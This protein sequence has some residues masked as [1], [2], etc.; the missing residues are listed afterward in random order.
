LT[1]AEFV[2]IMFTGREDWPFLVSLL[3]IETPSITSERRLRE[4]R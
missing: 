4:K 3:K 2:T 1:K